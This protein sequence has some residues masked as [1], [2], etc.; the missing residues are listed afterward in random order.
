VTGRDDL[1]VVLESRVGGR[2]FERTPDGVEHEWGEVTVWEPPDRLEYLWH[3]RRD[4]SDATEVSVQFIPLGD[5]STLVEIEHAGWDL[6]GADAEVWRGRNESGWRT[7][8]PHFLTA[9]SAIKATT[10]SEEKRS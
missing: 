1:T 8:V 9:V 6:L 3:L 5:N 2:I 10:T 7:L 4:R